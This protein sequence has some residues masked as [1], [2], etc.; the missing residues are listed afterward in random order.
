MTKTTNIVVRKQKLIVHGASREFASL[1]VA[2]R[3]P[4]AEIS[5][6]RGSAVAR[7]RFSRVFRTRI[8]RVYNIDGINTME[9]NVS[10]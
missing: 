3:T 7:K 5:R 1:T 4:H 8:A 10:N 6:S 9:R 2:D